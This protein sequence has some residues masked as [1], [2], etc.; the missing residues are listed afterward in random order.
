MQRRAHDGG[1]LLMQALDES[2]IGARGLIA[3]R[4][5]SLISTIALLKY[6][7]GQTDR[8]TNKQTYRH[9]DG[10]ISDPLP[11]T[12]SEV[13]KPQPSSP[14]TTSPPQQVVQKYTTSTQNIEIMKF[15][16]KEICLTVSAY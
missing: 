16:Y 4:G 10:N 14:P 6:A 8:Q 9:T 12:E 11:F 7:R 1:R 2:I 15:K 5:R 3:H 13:T